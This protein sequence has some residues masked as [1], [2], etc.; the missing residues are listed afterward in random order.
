[1]PVATTA[2]V[3]AVFTFS[4]PNWAGEVRGE[5]VTFSTLL[6]TVLTPGPG[7]PSRPEVGV[8][9]LSVAARPSG[10]LTSLDG[11]SEPCNATAVV[12]GGGW[13]DVACNVS[14]SVASHV[15]LLAAVSV[16]SGAV[17]APTSALVRVY[18]SAGAEVESPLRQ[19]DVALGGSVLLDGLSVDTR[20]DRP[21]RATAAACTS[22]RRAL[23]A[24]NAPRSCC[25]PRIFPLPMPLVLF[26]LAHTHAGTR[27]CARPPSLLAAP[28]PTCM[29]MCTCTFTR[30]CPP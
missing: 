1:M 29:C 16:H 7:S 15:A 30:T 13:G 6:L 24:R 18:D 23:H 8:G 11:T 4:P 9:G 17:P 2:D 22:P 10:N 12:T 20:C 21:L 14:V 28:R 25:G 5:W 27:L 19:W 26:A 3:A